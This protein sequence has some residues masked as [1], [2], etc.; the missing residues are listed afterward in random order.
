HAKALYRVLKASHLGETYNIGGLNEKQNIDVVRLI[1]AIM[2]EQVT[3]KPT[4]V[5]QFE[6]L[7]TFV[8]DR[9]GHDV[10]YAI[11]ANK[12]NADLDWRPDEDFESGIRKTVEW[13]LDNREWW[14]RV[15][16][17]SYRL[18]RLGTGE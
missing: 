8:R 12:I 13:Y 18:G 11:D 17:G 5:E 16:D 9:P 14:Q 15:L 6:D 4:G 1:C 2:D 7:I 3:D 10:R